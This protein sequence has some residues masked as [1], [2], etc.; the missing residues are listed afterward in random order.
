MKTINIETERL[1]FLSVLQS[2]N[3]VR[4]LLIQKLSTSHFGLEHTHFGYKVFADLVVKSGLQPSMDSFLATPELTQDTIEDIRAFSSTIHPIQTEDDA[5]TTFNILEYYRKIRRTH[6]FQIAMVNKTKGENAKPEIQELVGEIE[7]ALAD[8]QTESEK[9]KQY[10]AGSGTDNS[11]E[12]LNAVLSKTEVKLH[13]TNFLNFDA[14]AGGLGRQDLVFLASKAKGGKSI[15]T[16]NMLINW[17]LQ[18]H[19]NV[20]YISM[21]MNE[22]EVMERILSSISTVEHTKIRLST[23][24][25]VE[26]GRIRQKWKEFQEHGKRH[27]CRFSILCPDTMTVPEMRMLFKN[28]GYHVICLDYL[29]L[30]SITEKNKADWEKL[31]ILGREL[32]QSTKYLNAMILSPIQMNDDG[33][34]RYSKALKEHANTV[35]A[36]LRR[37]EDEISHNIKVNQLVT[38][39][40]PTFP[41]MLKEDFARMSVTNGLAKVPE[42]HKDKDAKDK[43][44][45]TLNK[46]Y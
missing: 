4:N 41:F 15:V 22:N 23:I 30:M 44:C 36:W 12:L 38:R 32:K 25:A 34:V 18:T 26:E 43:K 42:E 5:Q 46:L 17:Y 7:T 10:H 8:L 20:C 37:E 35:W 31:S 14:Q 2:P 3:E 27:G 21:E 33:D 6:E 28:R 19:L 11:D 29:N 16:L 45:K 1:A 9:A 13:P 24:S 40:G 39:S